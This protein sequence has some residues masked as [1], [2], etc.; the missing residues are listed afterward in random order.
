LIISGGSG[1]DGV[2]NHAGTRAQ[3]A[4][5]DV[6]GVQYFGGG[7]TIHDRLGCADEDV[8]SDDHVMQGA[9]RSFAAGAATAF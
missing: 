2:R 8:G 3:D 4:G 6:A 9:N 7:N 5:D 1:S